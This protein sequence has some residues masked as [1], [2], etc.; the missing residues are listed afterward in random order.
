MKFDFIYFLL[1]V[2]YIIIIIII[3]VYF[4]GFPVYN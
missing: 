3:I 1:R 2:K 4:L